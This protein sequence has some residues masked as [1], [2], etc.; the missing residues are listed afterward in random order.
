[1]ADRLFTIHCPRRVQQ[2]LLEAVRL[3]C[4]ETLPWSIVVCP[5]RPLRPC[6]C[7]LP[8]CGA[9]PI[10]ANRPDKLWCGTVPP[11][12]RQM[13]APDRRQRLLDFRSGRLTSPRFRSGSSMVVALAVLKSIKAQI[14]DSRG[15]TP[16]TR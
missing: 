11:S 7:F 13:L 3:F 1:M 6:S 16:A 12:T 10:G 14:N 2:N 4:D 15:T 5:C 9:A 8:D